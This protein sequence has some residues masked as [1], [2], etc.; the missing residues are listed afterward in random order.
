[1]RHQFYISF[2]FVAHTLLLY[3]QPYNVEKGKT[4][5]RFAQTVFGLDINCLSGGSSSFINS[6]GNITE[7]GIKPSVIPSA[8][9][10]GLHF[11]GH[12]EFY[13]NI[14]LAPGYKI[15]DGEVSYSAFQADIFGT[16]IYP[17][18]IQK[19][20]LAPFVGAS[21]STF[22]Y[23]QFQ[24]PANTKAALH[25]NYFIPLNAG[26]TWYKKGGWLLEAGVSV[27]TRA[28]NFDYYLSKTTYG[29]LKTHPYG[30]WLGIRKVLETTISSEKTYAN[31]LTEKRY[32]RLK[33]QHKLNSF[34]FG[35]GPSS[36][37]FTGN[38]NWLK[39][40]RPYINR[41]IAANIFPEIVTGYHYAP[42][43]LHTLAVF[44]YNSAKAEA[45]NTEVKMQRLAAGL[46]AHVQL[47]D[48][49][50]FVPYIGLNCGYEQL[51]FTERENTK[52]VQT[53]QREKISYGFVFGWD[54]LPD[55]LQ[56]FTLRTNMRY[57]PNLNISMEKG[58]QMSLDQL[59]F[60]FIQFIYYPERTRN[61]RRVAKEITE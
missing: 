27:N 34:F 16:K 4:R 20:R 18:R 39:N 37:F 12:T 57:F 2:F 45:Y 29:K 15:K 47:F 40:E 52:I 54:I 6:A 46:E 60:N 8:H 23:R 19:K 25:V 22:T 43:Q 9:I 7:F 3:Q 61:I 21:V 17:I 11:W 48:Y 26:L 1:M 56:P 51:K 33:E 30:I 42:L 53:K 58:Y 59:E 31:G 10:A 28:K 14:P 36:A 50:G 35:A 24:Y 5:H 49:H 55:K 41:K 32:Q 13:F 44:R 38:C